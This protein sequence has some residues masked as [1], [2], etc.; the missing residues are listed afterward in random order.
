[1]SDCVERV[2]NQWTPL[3]S[4]IAA[5]VFENESDVAVKIF[6]FMN[7]RFTKPYLEF[8]SYAL[9]AIVNI[10]KLFQTSTVVTY[11]LHSEC[12]KLL[13]F[14]ATN[15]IK[16]KYIGR[17]DLHKIDVEK[18]ENLLALEIIYPGSKCVNSL[19]EIENSNG[20]GDREKIT[21][22]YKNVKK[23]YQAAF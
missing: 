15:F 23:I 20:E 7:D 13:R 17:S 11:C 2:L 12:Y 8:L 18:A 14:L 5:A 19:R 10:N 16:T 1:M 22:F 3:F 21:Q 4:T 9:G 6:N